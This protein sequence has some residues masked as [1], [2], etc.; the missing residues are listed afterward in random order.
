MDFYVFDLTLSR[1][2]HFYVVVETFPFM[3]C[4]FAMEWEIMDLFSPPNFTFSEICQVS[5]MFVNDEHME[6]PGIN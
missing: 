1:I 2:T 4:E 3:T 6:K 5:G